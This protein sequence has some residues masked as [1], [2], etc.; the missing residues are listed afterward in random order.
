MT[1]ARRHLRPETR[2]LIEM[3][4]T[5]AIDAHL[6]EI[7]NS[8]VGAQVADPPD[9]RTNPLPDSSTETHR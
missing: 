6:A 3:I 7:E 5:A 2:A 9:A 4:A 1:S 8:N